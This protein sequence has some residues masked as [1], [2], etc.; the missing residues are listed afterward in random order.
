LGPVPAISHSRQP[1]ELDRQQ[2]MSE[3]AAGRSPQVRQDIE[4]GRDAYTAGANQVVVHF[5]PAGQ[6]EPTLPRRVWG[7]VP[8]RNLGFTGREDLLGAVRAALTGADQAVVQAL[9]G[10]GGVGKTQ[11]ATEYAYR[12]A[13]EYDIVWWVNAEQPELITAQF[14]ALAE[15]LGCAEAGAGPEAVRTRLLDVLRDRQRWLLVFDTAENPEHVA[16]WLPGRGG[17]VLITSR[18]HGWDELAVPVDVDVMNRDESVA[19]LRRRVP[20]L[21]E[22]EAA[23][24]AAAVG[25]LPLAIAQA[26]A[27]MAPAGTTAS[28][29]VRLVEER[30]AEILDT[31]RPVSYRLSLAAVTQLALDRL[32]AVDPAAAQAV[33][34]CAFLAPDPVPA[35]WFTSAAGQLPEPLSTVAADPLA[36][37]QALARIS[38]QALARID[39]QGLMT[40]RLTQAIIR[41]RLSPGEAAIIRAQAAALLSA[42]HP[43]DERLPSTWPGWARLL[44]HLLVLD[45]STSTAALSDLTCDAVHYLICRGIGRSAHGLARQLYQHR[46]GQDGPDHSNTLKAARA[47]DKVLLEVELYAEARELAEDTLVRSRRV[48]GE[49]HP[50]TLTSADGLAGALYQLGEYLAARELSEDILARRRRVLGEDHPDTLG[51]ASN[52]AVA[53]YGLGE[54]G[55]ARDLDEDTLARRRRVL[56]EDH[57]DTL[58]SAGNLAID[59]YMLGE[60]LAARELSEDILARRRRVLGEDHPDTVRSAGNL[61]AE[62]YMLGEYGAA[63]DLDEDILA[64]RRRVLGEDHPDT[65]RSASNLAADL[66]ALGEVPERGRNRGR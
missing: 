15:A 27:Y 39:A 56:G 12:Y 40:H 31:G 33:R 65:V 57:P 2:T 21:G 19:L 62:L 35:E 36:W 24:V 58:T 60:Y 52:L 64:R 11:L 10:M 9:H 44:P 32:E 17:H 47:L 8:A 61:A 63:R 54:Y 22:A 41:T 23:L 26:A 5:P 20:G 66:R 59:L 6:L 3:E 1:G 46:L 48:L 43:G 49:D 38:G 29:Y 37:G 53:V 4:V 42:S 55:T 34:V 7:D 45:P 50:D 25:D 16:G 28:A 30:A 14:A 51:F 13:T 18:A